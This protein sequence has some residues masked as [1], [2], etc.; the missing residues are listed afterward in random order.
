[1]IMSDK[2]NIDISDYLKYEDSILF[3][4]LAIKE[5]ILFIEEDSN[6]VRC[7]NGEVKV[8]PESDFRKYLL[9]LNKQRKKENNKK[10]LHLIKQEGCF[11]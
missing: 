3:G 5:E 7:I 1:M 2:F 4:E 11:E 8:N 10:K 9:C 6:F